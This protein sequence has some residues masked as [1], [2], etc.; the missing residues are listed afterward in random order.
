MRSLVVYGTCKSREAELGHLD[1][2]SAA[3]SE[4]LDRL[5][6][7]SYDGPRRTC[8]EVVVQSF[9]DERERSRYSQVCLYH[10]QMVVLRCKESSESDLCRLK[11]QQ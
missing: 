3:A 5:H 2:H 10:L 6:R 11:Q 4:H 8:H 7:L 9:A 1:P